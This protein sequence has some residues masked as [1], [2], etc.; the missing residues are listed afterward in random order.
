MRRGDRCQSDRLDRLQP[1][2]RRA[3]PRPGHR[4]VRGHVCVAALPTRPLD[5]ARAVA[6][7]QLPKQRR[8]RARAGD[9]RRPRRRGGQPGRG[10]RGADGRRVRGAGAGRGVVVLH[11]LP[12]GVLALMLAR[13]HIHNLA[14]IERAE[15]ELGPGL[16]VLTGET[17]AGKTMLAQ[18]I[19]LL[20]GSQPVAGM[21]GPHGDEAYVEAEFETPPEL[22]ND[23]ALAAVAGLRPDGEETLVVA[24]RLTANGRSRAFVWGRGC[25]RADLEAIGERLIEMS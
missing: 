19:G 12:G 10:A 2:G 24:R 8:R 11:P 5:G 1:L 21:V 7:G 25:A 18:A 4:R 15:L 16:N 23:P 3:G 17:G 20:T 9:R 6:C 22:F 13:L 14:L